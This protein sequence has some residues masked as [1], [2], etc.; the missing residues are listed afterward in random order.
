M[1]ITAMKVASHGCN[2]ERRPEETFV[3]VL[4]KETK[5]RNHSMTRRT[6]YNVN[7]RR[8]EWSVVT[9]FIKMFFPKCRC[10]KE[11]RKEMGVEDCTLRNKS[12]F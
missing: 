6:L 7:V 11:G 4:G 2:G 9:S 1:S 12:G 8:S 3:S 5:E 10:G